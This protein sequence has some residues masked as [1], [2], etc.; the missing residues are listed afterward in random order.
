[1]SRVAIP[2]EARFLFATGD[3]LLRAEVDLILKTSSG[4]WVQER[5]LVDTGSE[6]TTFPAALAKTLD[7]PMPA[8]AA[9][10]AIHAQTGLEI[11]S[12]VLRFQV[13]GTDQTEYV[14][15]CL[16]LGDP[17]APAV[18]PAA[19]RPRKLL[20]PLGL[21]RRLRFTLEDNQAAGVPYGEMV[22]EK[23]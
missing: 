3:L 16:F 15:G 20:Q 11:R 6:M 14:V 7:L 23:R 9:A 10:G 13:A 12:G 19:N 4:A 1:M 17:D 2:V 8:K 22:I 5:F 18:T 21:I